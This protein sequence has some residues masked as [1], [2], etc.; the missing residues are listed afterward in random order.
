[1]RFGMVAR[2][3]PATSGAWM[4]RVRR[5]DEWG[6]DVLLIPDHLGQ[7]SPFPPLVAAAAA[8]ERLRLGVQ[9]CNVCFWNPALLARDAATV[10]LLT[11]GRLELGFGAGH[12]R[13]EFTAAGIEYE[14]AGLRVDRLAAT[15]GVLRRLLA[16]ETV[17]TQEPLPMEACTIG[18]TP[19]QATVPIMV[20]GNGDRVLQ[21]AATRADIVGLVG[22]TSGTGRHHTDLSHFAWAG[23]A[24]RIDHVRRAAG[25]RFDA[26][27]LSVLVQR[28]AVTDDRDTAIAEFIGDAPI[29]PTA[30]DDSPFVLAGTSAHIAEQL[31]RL[32]TEHGVTYVTTFEASADAL[33]A[34]MSARR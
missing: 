28:V 3:A 17:T 14:P 23:L 9:V 26:L 29:S 5:V 24:E 15:V 20:G 34:A 16:G 32:R 19:R 21:I 31:D 33:A 8:S 10:D 30:V 27:E 25:E 22:F 4:D 2:D 1:M 12:A 6:Y 11:D 7:I 13:E 18:I